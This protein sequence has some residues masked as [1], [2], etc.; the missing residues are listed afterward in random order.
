[1]LSK[2]I[3][4]NSILN[5]LLFKIIIVHWHEHM[6]IFFPDGVELSYKGGA[7]QKDK[8]N[9]LANQQTSTKGVY[10]RFFIC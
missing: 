9:H 2:Y 10:L 4:W 1:M 6:Q 8:T 5:C 7:R 3:M